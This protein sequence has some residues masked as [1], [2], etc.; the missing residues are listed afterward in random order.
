MPTE[1]AEDRHRPAL[2]LIEE[3][4]ER[5]ALQYSPNRY[6]GLAFDAAIWD[7]RPVDA[8]AQERSTTRSV[9]FTERGN[10]LPEAPALLAPFTD[11]VKAWLVLG[12]FKP[13]TAS[14]YANATRYL[15][16]AIEERLHGEAF[17][18]KSWLDV[19]PEDF[20][21]AEQ[22]AGGTGNK[23]RRHTKANVAHILKHFA[24]WLDANDICPGLEWT[25]LT[26]KKNFVQHAT[27]QGKKER[28][29][30][31]PTKRAI[32]SCAMIYRV[33]ALPPQFHD[34]ARAPDT[35]LMI[36][37]VGLLMVAGLRANELV[38]LPYDCLG[39]A[40]HRGK[41]RYYL[42]YWNEKSQKRAGHWARRWLSPLGAELAK[43]LIAELKE[44]TADA[45]EQARR[46]ERAA[47]HGRVPLP[48]GMRLDERVDV[49][50]L[51]ALH[52]ITRDGMSAIISANRQRGGS[53]FWFYHPPGR[54]P[55]A[56]MDRADIE[57]HLVEECGPLVVHDLGNGETQK[58]SDTLLI[59]PRGLLNTQRASASPVF[60]EALTDGDLHKWLN[61]NPSGRKPKPSIFAR[62]GLREPDG[63]EVKL[64]PHSPRHWLNTIANKAGMTALQITLWM[65]RSDPVHTLYYLHDQADLADLNR[66]GIADGLIDGPHR[67]RYQKLPKSRRELYLRGLEQAHKLRDGYCTAN[68]V[69]E[70]CPVKKI[71]EICALHTRTKGSA[72][73]REARERKRYQVELALDVYDRA[74]KNGIRVHPRLLGL[75]S[76]H[77]EALNAI[78]AEDG[79][80]A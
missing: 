54:G 36:C 30:R 25:P 40:K 46:L 66:E 10:R 59:H 78:L 70:G 3:A 18:L 43:A 58:L 41:E 23:S 72:M 15:W 14:R 39:R 38:T 55:K 71:C 48:P 73:E 62:F 63:S 53:R 61:G 21:R 20:D 32:E 27:A 9:R 65:Q 7:L 33:D 51:A 57:K 47:E 29:D 12:S 1:H 13:K 52:G 77:L 11:V 45:R 26:K 34:L 31:L 8:S 42:R 49:A 24:R 69:T 17:A 2:I 74:A 68:T 28:L 76:G 67:K 5:F 56:W 6:P 16:E 64:R 35:R 50:T 37:A 44:L 75:Y 80:A 60:V 22:I 79:S 19:R 4:R